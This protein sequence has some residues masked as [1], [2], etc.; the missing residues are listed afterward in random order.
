MSLRKCRKQKGN[1]KYSY[2]A[3]RSFDFSAYHSCEI[4]RPYKLY[5]TKEHLS[6]YGHGVKTYLNIIIGC[7]KVFRVV[8]VEVLQSHT[9]QQGC[10]CAFHKAGCCN[11]TKYLLNPLDIGC[12]H[13]LSHLPI[14]QRV[15]DETT[16]YNTDT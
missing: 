12:L 10:R 4:Y 15:L 9:L 2:Y 14:Y 16:S 8:A 6:N 3:S 1:F 5:E 11:L 13:V 7:K